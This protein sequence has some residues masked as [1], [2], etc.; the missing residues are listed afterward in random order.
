MPHIGKLVLAGAQL[1]S[2]LWCGRVGRL[3]TRN[4]STLAHHPE[5]PCKEDTC[6]KKERAAS[7]AGAKTVFEPTPPLRLRTQKRRWQVIV[8]AFASR[9]HVSFP[10]RVSIVF[11]YVPRKGF[12]IVVDQRVLQFRSTS[13]DDDMF[14]YLHVAH[15][16]AALLSRHSKRP[17]PRRKSE[18]L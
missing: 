7:R 18:S 13:L 2:W 16:S 4:R 10:S 5:I 12:Q 9:P 3:E 1:K 8:T 6:T 15:G 11:T 17:W 14:M